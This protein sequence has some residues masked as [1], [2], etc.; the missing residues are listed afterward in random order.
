[1]KTESPLPLKFRA[2]EF[3]GLNLKQLL[4]KMEDSVAFTNPATSIK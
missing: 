3:A 4:E 2:V 1:M